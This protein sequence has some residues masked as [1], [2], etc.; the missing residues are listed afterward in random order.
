MG[1]ERNDL[2]FKI[3]KRLRN[4]KN[5]KREIRLNQFRRGRRRNAAVAENS[6]ENASCVHIILLKHDEISRTCESRRKQLLELPSW[7]PRTGGVRNPWKRIRFLNCTEREKKQCEN[8]KDCF[9]TETLRR[10]DKVPPPPPPF[11]YI[12]LYL[13]FSPLP[14]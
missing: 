8:W 13:F 12:P 9:Q 10:A 3:F 14:I 7:L 2:L 1:R 11:S 4:K 5:T 6:R